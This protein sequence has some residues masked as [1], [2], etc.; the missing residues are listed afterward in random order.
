MHGAHEK[1]TPWHRV[2]NSQGR[3]STAGVLLPADKQQRMLEAEGVEFNAGGRCNLE[4]V[5]WHPAKKIDKRK[6]QKDVMR[7][8]DVSS[9]S[10]A[11]S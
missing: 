11:S 5:I 7:C 8:I 6:P 9:W 10:S 2:I 3:C 1:K 4:K